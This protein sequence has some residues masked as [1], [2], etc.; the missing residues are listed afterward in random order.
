MQ[1][2]HGTA[3]ETLRYPNFGEQIKQWTNVHGLSQTPTF[4][5]N[6]QSSYTRTR[7]GSSGGMAP[8]EAISMQDVTHNLP[9][10]AAQVMRFFGLDGTQ[11]TPGPPT[12]A[13]AR[14]PLPDAAARP[15]RRPT[16]PPA[17]TPP[18]IP[19]APAGSATRSTP[20]APA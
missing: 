12:P 3:D 10:D 5:D 6:P 20:G 18:P 2:W 17:D 13:R 9:V 11:P 15:R 8:V 7:Y 14:R 1:I 4:T 19:R 16:T